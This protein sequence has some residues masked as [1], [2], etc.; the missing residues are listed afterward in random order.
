MLS[1]EAP[2]PPS[3]HLVKKDQPLIFHLNRAALPRAPSQLFNPMTEK[4]GPLSPPIL[5]SERRAE[6]RKKYRRPPALAADSLSTRVIIS[7]R[8][9]ALIVSLSLSLVEESYLYAYRKFYT[10]V[11]Q[12]AMP[13]RIEIPFQNSAMMMVMGDQRDDAARACWDTISCGLFFIV[14]RRSSLLECGMVFPG[15]HIASVAKKFFEKLNQ[16]RRLVGN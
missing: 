9:A 3:I 7:T 13:P 4:S 14:A 15:F 12:G 11:S 8:A 1:K 6:A 16:S 5:R 2:P 10:C